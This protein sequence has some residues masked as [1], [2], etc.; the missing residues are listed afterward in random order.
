MPAACERIRCATSSTKPST[1][2]S[3]APA[4]ASSVSFLAIAGAVIAGCLVATVPC[5]SCTTTKLTA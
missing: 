4:P 3:L 5:S 1:A 2:S